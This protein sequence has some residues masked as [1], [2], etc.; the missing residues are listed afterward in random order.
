LF[1]DT[2]ITINEKHEPRWTERFCARFLMFT[3]ATTPCRCQR[4]TAECMW[5]AAPTTPR[6]QSITR[7]YTGKVN[8]QELLAGVWHFLRTR[9]ISRFNPGKK[10]PLNSIKAQMIAAGRRSDGGAT[11]SGGVCKGMPP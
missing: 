3:T 6:T 11:D 8:D 2:S 9:D 4:P 10:A 1:T 7:S 5:C